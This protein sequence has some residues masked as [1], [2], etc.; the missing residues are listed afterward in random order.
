MVPDRSQATDATIAEAVARLSGRRIERATYYLL[1]SEHEYE[2]GSFHAATM[3]VELRLT[4]A[5]TVVACWGDAFGH[6]GLEPQLARAADVFKN[7]PT[8]YDVSSH[9]WWRRFSSSPATARLIWRTGYVDRDDPAPVALQL[10]THRHSVWIFA[11]QQVKDDDAAAQR[12]FLLGLDEV[13][14]TADPSLASEL[15]LLE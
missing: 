8:A 3:G 5:T 1:P 7:D 10:A 14:V 6:F 9:P 2:H 15:G 4:D 11:A 12:G 13:F